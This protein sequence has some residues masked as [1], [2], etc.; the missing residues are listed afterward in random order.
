MKCRMQSVAA[1]GMSH[2][3]D[4]KSRSLLAPARCS[5]RPFSFICCSIDSFTVSM[6]RYTGREKGLVEGRGGGGGGRETGRSRGGGRE[7]GRGRVSE[8]DRQR[9]GEVGVGGCIQLEGQ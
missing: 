9:Q 7:K 8:R 1:E 6:L 5:P 4:W 2:F 3:S